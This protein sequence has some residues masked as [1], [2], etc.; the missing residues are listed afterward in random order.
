MNKTLALILFIGLGLTAL[1]F[2]LPKGNVSAKTESSVAG[3][4]NRDAN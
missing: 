1:I 2:Q 3:G 4:A